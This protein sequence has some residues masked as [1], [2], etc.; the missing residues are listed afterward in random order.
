MHFTL[1]TDLAV[2]LERVAVDQLTSPSEIVADL[3]EQHLGR[4]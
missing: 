1:P 3:I 2:A 4:Y